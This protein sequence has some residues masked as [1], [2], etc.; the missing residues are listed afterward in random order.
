[1]ITCVAFLF[2]LF[3][4]YLATRQ[5]LS[6]VSPASRILLRKCFVFTLLMVLPL[7]FFTSRYSLYVSS[8]CVRVNLLRNVRV[9]CT[10]CWHSGVHQGFACTLG[11]AHGVERSIA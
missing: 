4:A 6:C 1:M 7:R 2:A 11:R 9:S 10:D 8:V 5:I 3:F